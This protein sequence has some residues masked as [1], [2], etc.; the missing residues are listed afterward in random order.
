MTQTI[1]KNLLRER[2]HELK[3]GLLSPL[4]LSGLL[5]KG[6]Q[7][8]IKPPLIAQILDPYEVTLEEFAQIKVVIF[9]HVNAT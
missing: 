9:A 5:H 7:E 4:K 3:K 1:R 8:Q 6:P 2:R